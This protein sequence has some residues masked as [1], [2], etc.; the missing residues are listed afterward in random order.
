MSELSDRLAAGEIVCGAGASTFAPAVVEVYGALGLDYVWLDLEHKGPSPADS[1][2]LERLVRAA[3]VAD[4]ELLVRVPTGAPW[5]VRKVLDTGVSNLLLARV[6]TAAAVRRA[7]RA[8]TVAYDDEPGA[9]GIGVSRASGWGS[10]GYE[11]TNDAPGLGVMVETAAAV[12][13]IDDI[14]AVPGLDFAYPGAADLAVSLGHPFEPEDA[15]VQE[16]LATVTEACRDAGVPQGRSVTA[17]ESVPDLVEDGWQLLRF[18]DEL[19]AVR[20]SLARFTDRLPDP[21]K[22]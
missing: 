18:G 11:P 14:L 16:A 19:G 8:A 13:A 22:N 6:E 2:A 20:R 21:S 5:L 3:D 1:N 7:A 17:A 10:D 12:D 4:V 15:I 9:R